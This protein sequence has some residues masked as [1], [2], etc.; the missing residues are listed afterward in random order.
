M[1]PELYQSLPD[2]L[3]LREVRVEV[4]PK[5]F[6]CRHLLLVTTLLDPQVYP[7]QELATAFRCRWH[8]E[9]D[10]RSIKHVMQMDVLRCKSPAMVRK[11]IWMHLLA[12]NR[13]LAASVH[14]EFLLRGYRQRLS[15]SLM[16]SAAR[17]KGRP[18]EPTRPTFWRTA[19]EET[20]I[21]RCPAGVTSGT[22][23]D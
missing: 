19:D 15:A 12:Y 13:V 21:G 1:S 5:G 6:R 17:G 11:E 10:L 7:R 9:L 8:A 18:G 22:P 3:S 23:G 2:T 14:E 4:S 20:A 16:G